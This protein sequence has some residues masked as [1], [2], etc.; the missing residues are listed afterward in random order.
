MSTSALHSAVVEAL[1]GWFDGAATL[2]PGSFTVAERSWSFEVRFEVAVDGGAVSCIGK[3]PR[4][5]GAWTLPEVLQS[6]LQANVAL[7]YRT[8]VEIDREV[9]D[10]ADPMLTSISPVGISEEHNLI[11]TRLLEA[12]PLRRVR[13]NSRLFTESLRRT[14]RWLRWFHTVIG[15]AAEAEFPLQASLGRVSGCTPD[16]APP[17][18]EEA[19]AAVTGMVEAIGTRPVRTGDIHGDANTANVLVTPE[20]RVAMLDPNRRRGPSVEDVSHLAG[21]LVTGRAR[22]ASGGLLPGRAATD[23]AMRALIG[24]YRLQEVEVFDALLRLDLLERWAEFESRLGSKMLAPIRRH[25]R[26]EITRSPT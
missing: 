18:W 11:V 10:A 2:T 3:V 26:R 21:E 25:L 17:G 16:P 14:G 1:P 6:G 22:T 20:Q 7:E 19:A 4:W 5:E 9:S 15:G 13:R 24:G 12:R 8:L 23:R